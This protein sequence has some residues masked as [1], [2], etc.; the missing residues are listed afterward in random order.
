[1]TDIRTLHEPLS[2]TGSSAYAALCT[3]VQAFPLAAIFAVLSKQ[4]LYESTVEALTNGTWARINWEVGIKLPLV[5]AV[6]A[7][8]W[9]RYVLD[10]NF[11]SWRMT[12]AD[13]AIPF[14]ISFVQVFF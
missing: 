6:V 9:H 2:K 7:V 4:T 12:W 1:M 8:V 5:V 13:A 14:A 11:M 3:V 10:N